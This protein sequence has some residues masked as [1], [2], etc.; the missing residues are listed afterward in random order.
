MIEPLGRKIAFFR[1]VRRLMLGLLVV[2]LVGDDDVIVF[3]NY[4]NAIGNVIN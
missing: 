4:A 2:G 3:V 1:K